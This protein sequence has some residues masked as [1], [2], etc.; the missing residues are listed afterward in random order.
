MKIDG[1][2]SLRIGN[3]FFGFTQ[4]L[5]CTSVEE[6]KIACDLHWPKN[7]ADDTIEKVNKASMQIKNEQASHLKAYEKWFNEYDWRKC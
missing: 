2:R 7:L 1:I 4:V 6:A 3:P 5:D